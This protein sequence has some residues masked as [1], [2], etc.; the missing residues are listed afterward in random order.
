[1][2]TSSPT[3][4]LPGAR[5]VTVHE[6]HRGNLPPMRAYLSE[7]WERRSFAFELSRSNLRAANY[8]T[9]FGQLWQVLNPFLLAMVYYFAW[10][11][12]AGGA[13]TGGADFLSFLIGGLFLY[14]YTRN[15]MGLGAGSIVGGGG[16]LLLNSSFPRAIL[17]LSSTI[18]AFLQYMPTLVVFFGFHLLFGSKLHWTMLLLPL[19]FIALTFFNL[20]LAMAA[21][22]LTVY[23]RDTSSFLPYLLR[24]WLYLSPILWTLDQAPASVRPIL[25]A[26]P[27]VPYLT[28]WHDLVAGTLPSPTMLIAMAFWSIVTPIFGGWFFLS[29]EREF[30]VRV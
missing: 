16:G 21:G 27:L 14:Y 18:T 17:P 9:V 12:I 11:V 7:V 24:I 4:G 13:K 20:G 25:I 10:G 8:D 6:P 28:A 3:I 19:L 30:A 5:D 23:F 22:A 26:N 2:A 15:S 29:R 1:M